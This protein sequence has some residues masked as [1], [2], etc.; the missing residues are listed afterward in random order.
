M[1]QPMC[2][3]FSKTLLTPIPPVTP[4]AS[5]KNW[6]P[7][8]WVASG[9]SGA[10]QDAIWDKA[11]TTSTRGILQRLTAIPQYQGALL[12]Y[13]WDELERGDGEYGWT[14]AGKK[15]GMDQIQER[16][17]QIAGLPGRRLIIF[18]QMKTFGS[19][20]HAA[21]QWMRNDTSHT[22]ESGE[23]FDGSASGEY[24]YVSNKVPPGPGGYVP[25]MHVNAVRDRFKALMAAFASRFNLNPYLEAIAVTEASISKPMNLAN[26]NYTWTGAATWF[27]NMTNAYV[28]MRSDLSNIQICQWVNS[29]RADMETWVDDIIAAGIG[30][31]MPDFCKDEKGFNFTRSTTPAG[32][33]G[34]IYWMNQSP[35]SAI[36]MVHMSKPAQEGSVL[37][38]GQTV[39]NAAPGQYAF[40]GLAWTRV[41]AAGYAKTVVPGTHRLWRHETSNQVDNTT[42]AGQNFNAVTD[43]AMASVVATHPLEGTARPT[44]WT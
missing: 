19:A 27:T 32:A 1:V 15:Y 2:S 14:I 16:L 12:R 40:P 8:D 6:N 17:D 7:G 24:A 33:P 43:A 36:R 13:S 39:A 21:P 23:T 29:D 30:V 41:E 20:S 28:Q 26:P 35:T 25:N 5:S 22:Y 38:P 9:T 10:S 44:G 3:A 11:G 18:I 31:G 42:Y 37:T 34:N 4:P